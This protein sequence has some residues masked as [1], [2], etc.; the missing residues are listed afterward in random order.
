MT[1]RNNKE[2][3][4][5]LLISLIVVS[6]VISIGL[7]ILD[8]TL[9]QLRLS[10]NSKESETA[11]HAA[12]AGL[13]CARFWRNEESE[14]IE[15]GNVLSPTCFGGK[16][17]TAS[18]DSVGA[19]GGASAYS[20]KFE[21]TWGT[22]LTTRCSEMDIIVVVSDFNTASVV[23]EV[24]IKNILPGYPEGDKTCPAG[25]VCTILSSKGYSRACE[26]KDKAGTVQREVLL[27]L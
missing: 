13:E 27:E 22:G 2:K 14:K 5:A 10:T 24:D 8:L 11:I 7:V 17:M 4:F 1:H 16:S 3:G 21:A 12:N 23:D 18:H 26:D 19:S 6:V 15:G 25:G 20:Y 9:K